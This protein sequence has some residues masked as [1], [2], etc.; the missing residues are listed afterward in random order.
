[1]RVNALRDRVSLCGNS[2]NKMLTIYLPPMPNMMNIYNT[3]L[4][5]NGI[6][7]PVVAHFYAPHFFFIAN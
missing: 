5:I 3:D 1:M 2:L 7:Y 4:I 6:Q